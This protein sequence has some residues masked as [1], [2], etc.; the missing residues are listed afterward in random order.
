MPQFDAFSFFNQIVW[1]SAASCLFYIVYL[2]LP[3]KTAA[4]ATKMRE[5]VKIFIS[6]VSKRIQAAFIYNTAIKLFVKK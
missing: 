2:K 4:E 3:I 5:K 1:F 6:S